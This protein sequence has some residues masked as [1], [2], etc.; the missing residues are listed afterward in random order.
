[1]RNTAFH[2]ARTPWVSPACLSRAA[3]L[4]AKLLGLLLIMGALL[5][6]GG[7]T[8]PGKSADSGHRYLLIFETT[9][10]MRPRIEGVLKT[11]QSLLGSSMSGQLRAGDTLGLWTFNE[12]L[13]TGRFPLQAW[14]LE[15][16]DAITG[17]VLTFVKAQACE[18]QA[19][20]EPIL[21]AVR[22]LIEK[23]DHI[24]VILFSSGAE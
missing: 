7:E 9:R 5:V 4:G 8:T 19:Q 16:A 6:L 22:S 23:S 2:L 15:D 13:N 3:L 10:T 1:M 14:S 24:T 21:F 18:Q 11:V 12:S 17:R 20:L